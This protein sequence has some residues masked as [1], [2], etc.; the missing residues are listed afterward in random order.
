[1][2]ILQIPTDLSVI[3]RKP[4]YQWLPTNHLTM[5]QEYKWQ[6]ASVL[7]LLYLDMDT[8]IYHHASCVPVQFHCHL[9][10]YQDRHVMYTLT[11]NVHEF[12]TQHHVTSLRPV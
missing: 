7:K 1:M 2:D 5:F 4:C 11:S 8:D 3:G 12:E 9:T 6:T 10:N